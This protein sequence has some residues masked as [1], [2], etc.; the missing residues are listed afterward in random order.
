METTN[1][2]KKAQTHTLR[3]KYICVMHTQ[4]QTHSWILEYSHLEAT[5]V[6]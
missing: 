2:T 5:T 6:N 1:G 4:T 3:R